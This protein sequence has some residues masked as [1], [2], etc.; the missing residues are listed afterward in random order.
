MNVKKRITAVLLA[1]LLLCSLFAGCGKIASAGVVELP[2]ETSALANTPGQSADLS[3]DSGKTGDMEMSVV[4]AATGLSAYEMPDTVA[5]GTL[6]KG[7]DKALVDYSNTADGYVMA[8]YLGT[9]PKVKIQITGPSAVTYTYNLS[10]TGEYDVFP[11]SEGNG[12]YKVSIY[13]NIAGTKYSLAFSTDFDVAL[14]DEFAPFLRANKYVNFTKTSKVYEKALQLTKDCKTTMETIQ[15]VYKYVINNVSYDYKL[16]ETV[17]SGYIPDVDAV[18]ASGK[19]I[20]FDYAA[21]MTA[22]LRSKG[23]PTKLV[24]GY[25]GTVY[26]AWIN[27]YSQE[28][29]WVLASIYFD[30]KQWK[31]MDPT[32]AS[33]GKS[34]VEIMKYIGNG[35]NYS[36]KY[37]Y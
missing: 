9:N 11:L 2:D 36:A 34:G 25:T 35:A 13:E 31:L 27:T 28:S 16:A 37:L 26:H 6:S 7:N 32:F 29:G 17:Q 1:A 30:G 20:C 3:S 21:L 22:M 24:V 4:P 12:S 5:P 19:G 14:E 15:A 33:S 8:K 23:V 18:L 10:L